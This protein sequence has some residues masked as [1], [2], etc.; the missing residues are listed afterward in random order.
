MNPEVNQFNLDEE[1]DAGEDACDDEVN[2]FYINDVED[3]E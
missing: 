3:D 1:G 2:T